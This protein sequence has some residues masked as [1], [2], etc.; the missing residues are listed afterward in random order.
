MINGF[1]GGIGDIFVD[2]GKR[3]TVNRFRNAQSFTDRFDK[4]R[5][6]RAHFSLEGKNRAGPDLQYKLSGSDSD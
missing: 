1:S 6:P 4:S 2:Y 5:L 3:R